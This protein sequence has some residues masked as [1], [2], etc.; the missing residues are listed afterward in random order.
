MTPTPIMQD[1][2][3]ERSHSDE[4]PGTAMDIDEAR[5]IAVDGE[6]TATMRRGN[7]CPGLKSCHC[8]RHRASGALSTLASVLNMLGSLTGLGQSPPRKFHFKV[9]CSVS[10]DAEHLGPEG[11]CPL[12][13]AI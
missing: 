7:L 2:P 9:T 1:M 11:R 13:I 10:D 5:P 6:R 12:G 8:L 4:T 3:A